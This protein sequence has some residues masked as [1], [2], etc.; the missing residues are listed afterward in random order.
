MTMLGNRSARSSMS[1]FRAVCDKLDFC[2]ALS[3]RDVENMLA[4]QGK[5]T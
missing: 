2:F 1:I 3:Y 4:E 5:T